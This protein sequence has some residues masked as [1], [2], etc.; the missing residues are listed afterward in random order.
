MRGL[1]APEAV[2][3]VEALLLGGGGGRLPALLGPAALLPA[4]PPAASGA[5]PRGW[6]R[7]HAVGGCTGRAEVT[8]WNQAGDAPP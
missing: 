3:R 4:L 2:A 7:P 6:P 1:A 5:L 8:G